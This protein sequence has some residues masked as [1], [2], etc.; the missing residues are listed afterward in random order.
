MAD[1]W[2]AIDSVLKLE[3][4]TLSG[5]VTIDRGGRT[6][7]GIAE[8]FHPELTNSLFYTSMGQIPALQ[9][10]RDIYD[11]SYAEPLSIAE[12]TNQDIANKLMSMGVNFGVNRASKMLQAAVC[13]TEDGV[14]GANTLLKLSACEPVDVL[15]YLRAE[16]ERFYRN[17]VL[18]HPDDEK[19]LGGWVTRARA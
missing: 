8:K 6:R 17:D 16:S 10:A 7:F 11:K 12:I 15:A 13:V 19:Y 14:T 4:S 9:L 5:I 3:D 18:D 1:A 2:V